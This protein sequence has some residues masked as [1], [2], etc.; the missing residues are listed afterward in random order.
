[1]V[2]IGL[3]YGR[4]K[5]GVAV[6]RQGLVLPSEAVFGPWKKILERLGELACDYDGI[7]IVLGLPLSAL[8]KPTE[9]SMEV[10]SFADKL[11]E[12]GYSVELVNEVGTSAAAVRLLGK[13][14][15]KGRVDSMAACEILKRFLN[16]YE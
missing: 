1:M 10:E 12:T 16:I 8:G 7:E 5:T 9:L 11:R 2:K 3:D 14:D 15:R 13:K 6:Y 4:K